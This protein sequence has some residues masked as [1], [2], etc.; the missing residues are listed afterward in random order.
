MIVSSFYKN[1]YITE[2]NTHANFFFKLFIN[3]VINILWKKFVKNNYPRKNYK[4]YNTFV[5]K[6]SW[7]IT[8]YK[9]GNIMRVILENKQKLRYLLCY[10]HGCV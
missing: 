5:K 7:N 2:E 1:M 8:N 3:F 4:F 9:S 10:C 6:K